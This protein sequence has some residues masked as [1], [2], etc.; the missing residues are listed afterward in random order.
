[1]SARTARARSGR[2]AAGVLAAAVAVTLAVTTT[3]TARAEGVRAAGPVFLEP[4][5][6]PPHPGGWRAGAV[7]PGLPERGVPCVEDGVLA[8]MEGR[9]AHRRF[10]TDLDTGASQVTLTAADAARAAALARAVERSV[11]HCAERIVAEDPGAE[12]ESRDLGAVNAGNGAHVYGVRSA[13]PQSSRDVNLFAVGRSGAKV[14]V[15]QW[16]RM[17]GWADAPVPAFKRT[18]ATA[19]TKLGR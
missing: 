11:R 9:A 7:E 6:L 16:G 19:V 13:H 1:M 2:S 8:G 12:A 4:S 18:T 14:T 10:H 3:G 5:E 15:V 17:G